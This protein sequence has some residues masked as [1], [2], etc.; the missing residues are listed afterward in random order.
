MLYEDQVLTD[1][2][3]AITHEDNTCRMQTVTYEQNSKVYELLTI[4]EPPVILNTSFND[5]GEP[6]VE[7]PY[8]AIRSFMK[9]DIDCLVIGDF[10]VDK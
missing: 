5:S 1:D 4:L 2:I 3:P 6:I 8:Q 10:I 7:T 9:M